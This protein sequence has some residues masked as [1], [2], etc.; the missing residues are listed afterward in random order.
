MA[1]VKEIILREVALDYND[2]NI[3][4]SVATQDAIVHAKINY[5][6]ARKFAIDLLQAAQN[7]EEQEQ[8]LIK[9]GRK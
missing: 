3:V 1:D 6:A 7:A 2:A 9:L 4:L 5:K 8:H